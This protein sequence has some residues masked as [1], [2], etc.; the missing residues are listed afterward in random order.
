VEKTINL[1]D[2]ST[3]TVNVPENATREQILR[4]VKREYEAGRIKG[5]KLPEPEPAPVPVPEPEPTALER[6]G[7]AEPLDKFLG[8][9]DAIGSFGSNL[10]A[11]LGQNVLEVSQLSPF[12]RAGVDALSYM[13]GN[14]TRE[15][16]DELRAKLPEELTNFLRYS[17]AS[18]TGQDI[19][20]HIGNDIQQA[21]ESTGVDGALSFIND[22]I[23]SIKNAIYNVTG[24]K[25]VAEGVT[26]IPAVAMELLPVAKIGKVGAAKTGGR[27]DVVESYLETPDQLKQ[28]NQAKND[29]YT[30]LYD[31]GVRLEGGTVNKA[32]DYVEEMLLRDGGGVDLDATGMAAKFR[33]QRAKNKLQKNKAGVSPS[34]RL[35]LSARQQAKRFPL[36]NSRPER[37]IYSKNQEPIQALEELKK[38][39]FKDFNPMEGNN[40]YARSQAKRHLDVFM[41]R[42]LKNYVQVNPNKNVKGY[43]K[44][45]VPKMIRTARDLGGRSIRAE[46]LNELFYSSSLKET[47][48][49]A[50]A[51]LR[52]GVRNI[53]KDKGQ[54]KFFSANEIKNMEFIA[55]NDLPDEVGVIRSAGMFAGRIAPAVTQFIRASFPSLRKMPLQSRANYFSKLVLK[56]TDRTE[57]SFAALTKQVIAGKT[58]DEAFVKYLKAVP[59]KNRN[60]F[61]IGVILSDGKYDLS[62]LTGEGSRLRQEA[63]DYAR[64][65]QTTKAVLTNTAISN[66]DDEENEQIY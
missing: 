35:P 64:G 20:E 7:K 56:T 11:D 54:R 65:I 57:K 1:P 24:S 19:K 37:P 45:D 60:A 36:Q 21:L 30:D 59:V 31:N 40:A 12:G 66:E 28:L 23:T 52:T 32:I 58:A 41:D 51:A 47:P 17:P 26:A 38:D 50:A 9:A 33:A 25:T 4:F 39:F 44:S 29:I 18:Q 22:S 55:R 2:G 5:K 6:F 14:D 62:K 48:D 63:L 10:A 16:S 42:Q 43:N 61:E 27:Q 13:S 46:Q 8:A 15:V 3:A 49:A 53:L 34:Q